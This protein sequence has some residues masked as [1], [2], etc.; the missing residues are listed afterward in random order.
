MNKPNKVTLKKEAKKK[1]FLELLGSKK[2]LGNVSLACD[3]LGYSR[4]GVYNWRKEDGKW[5]DDWD[6]IV[7]DAPERKADEAELTIR[8][9]V[10]GGNITAAIY[11]LKCLR[12]KVWRERYEHTGKG[13]G[14]IKLRHKISTDLEGWL[15]KL[16]KK[17]LN[18]TKNNK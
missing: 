12:P 1:K 8:K 16:A 18:E 17:K 6:E 9:A 13:G 14:P 4:T 15:I 5:A 11:T 3:Q 2:V 7:E 10:L